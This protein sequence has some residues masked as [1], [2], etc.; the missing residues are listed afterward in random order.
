MK[1]INP[2]RRRQA[3]GIGKLLAL[4]LALGIV[5]ASASVLSFVQFEA[6]SPND[7]SPP[8]APAIDVSPDLPATTDDLI[9]TVTA[10]SSDPDGDEIA[11]TYRWYN[12]G[13]PQDELNTSTLD[14]SHTTKN[15]VW[16]CMVI[17]SDGI[18]SIAILS[19]EVT[20]LN[21][22]PTAPV[23]DVTPDFPVTTDD[24]LCSITSEGSDADGD[25]ITYTYQWYRDDEPQEELITSTVDF[26]YTAPGD[27]WKCVVTSGDDEDSS[28]GS[29]D[30]VIIVNATPTAPVLEITPDL[31]VTT[32]DLICS[33]TTDGSDP[34][35]DA[36]IYTYQWYKDDELQEGLTTNTV[37]SSYT[38]KD[39]LWRCVV[40]Y[41]DGAGASADTFA[42][43]TIYNSPPSAPVMDVS[44]DHPDT[45]EDLVC[46]I[47][48]PGSDPDG[49]TITYTYQWY[50]NG[51][52]QTDLTAN[53]IDSSYTTDDDV[54]RCVV[55]AHDGTVG[56]AATFDE[57]TV[58]DDTA[59]NPPSPPV[60]NVTP[61]LPVTT[62]NLICTITTPSSD[63]D[64][65][66]ITY[67]YQW[68]KD[69]E[70][71]E[72]LTTSTIDS[73]YTAQAQVWSCVVIASDGIDSSSGGLDEV[74]IHNG[75]PTAPAVDVT[76]DSPATTDDLV[77]TITTA[78]SDP[79]GDSVTYSYQW[80]KD[81][82]LQ[83][84]LTTNTLDS[85]YT[86]KGQ[87]WRC[88]VTAR[89]GIAT[90]SGGSDEVTILNTS[91]TAPAVDVTPN[92]PVTS[93]DI[94][95]DIATASSDPDGDFVTYSYQWYKDNALQGSLTT[96]T[97]DSDYTAKDQVWKCV[98]TAS[99]GVDSNASGFDSVTVHNSPPTTPV[100]D[101]TPNAP[102]T[103]DNLL[104]TI[105]TQSSDPDTGDSISYSYAWYKNDALQS[106][107]TTKS[108]PSSRT[109][110]GETW[111]CV[112]TAS[113]GIDNSPGGADQV[114]VNEQ[115]S[116]ATYYV[117]ANNG[118]DNYDG[119]TTDTPFRTIGKAADVVQAGDVVQIR[120]GTYSGFTLSKSGITIEGVSRTQ[121]I[122]NG[123][124]NIN[125]SN[126]VVKN[127]T[128]INSPGDG[129]L[130]RGNNNTLQNIEVYD[131]GGSGIR[132]VS[133]YNNQYLYISSHDNYGGAGAAA[134][135]SDGISFSNWSGPGGDNLVRGSVF[136][137]NSDDGLDTWMSTGNTIENSI[138]YNNGHY[139]GDGNG[140]KLGEEGGNTIRNCIAYNN[141][142]EGF[143]NNG[144]SSNRFYNNTSYNNNYDFANWSYEH[145]NLFR[146]NLAYGGSISV[147][148]DADQA[149]NSWNLGISNPSFLSTNP[150]SP[151]FLCLSSTSPCRGAGSDGSDL[152][153]LQYGQTI[154][155]LVPIF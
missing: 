20:I 80:Y 66:I 99:D 146:N 153:A 1:N 38:S 43:V 149:Y 19:D 126:N 27:T 51:E 41:D 83:G 44:P 117:D 25:E 79:D 64:E 26:I 148:G 10:P 109:D 75:V 120:T 11:Y 93:D 62:N 116:E 144:G 14:S 141:S 59:N 135:D 35:G 24:L 17:A 131:S 42:E 130:V 137:N 129:I 138:V 63:P 7:N 55:T 98:A 60:V 32:D 34:E 69:D 77:C 145:N 91:P 154:T 125:G 139:G 33:I 140:F 136:Y 108:V 37:D 76:P 13:E 73:S 85:D 127:L 9:C 90:S 22:T 45:N 5:T 87:I 122:I 82:A 132:N 97:V 113:D 102:N 29:L 100:V 21:S 50:K 143:N 88:M 103:D 36:I 8:F 28:A 6:Q 107:L 150:S 89:D 16:R 23:V 74:T 133:S 4:I 95:C 48:V 49:D 152:G 65:D 104:C 31:P 18:D 15:Q 147:G 30:E 81:D 111:S 67:T 92:S 155:D 57:V 39:E 96:N 114:N 142:A 52:L 3:T 151:D 101:V 123:Q 128:A 40:T 58:G 56:T 61:D 121:V 112:V 134:A 84:S 78:S 106:D 12:N 86:A 2:L 47:S 105:T 71:Q 72:G 68:Y 119:R 110:N 94:T 124:I 70:L 54:W 53:T 46:S 115:S 118:N